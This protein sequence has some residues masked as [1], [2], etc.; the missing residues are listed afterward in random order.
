MW[1][2]I[3][4]YEGRYRVNTKGQI[5]SM[6]NGK[7]MSNCIGGNGYYKVGLRKK[8][9][10]KDR[11]L[12]HRLIA[13]HFIPNPNNK[14]QVNHIDGNKLNNNVCNLEW[15]TPKENSQHAFKLGL[16]TEHY[17]NVGKKFGKTSNY[18]YVSLVR[19]K[20]DGLFYRAL[21]KA[22][23]NGKLFAKSRQFSVNKFGEFE[24]ER[25]AALASNEIVCKYKEFNGYALNT[26]IYNV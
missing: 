3:C 5:L 14:P 20:A 24:A 13:E 18:H 12:V 7:I 11:L 10:R 8:S 22:T 2:D 17:K 19:S 23:I 6:W 1:K 16:R 15:C 25:L 4:G 9:G 21:V 26:V